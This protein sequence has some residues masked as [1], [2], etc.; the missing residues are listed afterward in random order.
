MGTLVFT[1]YL[2]SEEPRCFWLHCFLLVALTFSL[3]LGNNETNKQK[4][5][6]PPLKSAL[7]LRPGFKR[8]EP[9][10]AVK[11]NG[12]FFT[13]WGDGGSR[14]EEQHTGHVHCVMFSPQAGGIKAP[15]VDHGGH[16]CAT[17]TP[18]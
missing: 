1:A 13:R 5:T 7:A 4:R 8:L 17:K 10:P 3:T 14:R 9:G 18:T 11:I 16:F 12:G 15:P 2:L 6:L